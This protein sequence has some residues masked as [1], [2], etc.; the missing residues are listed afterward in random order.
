MLKNRILFTKGLAAAKYALR[1]VAVATA[2]LAISAPV[3][4]ACG[5]NSFTA[6]LQFTGTGPF[7]GGT[8]T[9]DGTVV[10]VPGD[11][12]CATD[13]VVRTNDVFVYRFNYK[14]PTGA[15]ENDITFTNTLPLGPGG[16]KIAVWDN[17]PPQCSGP[18]SSVSP[19]GLTLVCNIGSKDQSAPG[20]GDL[21]SS[22][23]AQV[24]STV[25]GANND[26]IQPGPATVTTS[27]PGTDPLNPV[28]CTAV[29][30]APQTPPPVTVSARPKVDFR[31][32][33]PYAGGQTPY[34]YNGVP[35]YLVSWYIYMDQAESSGTPSSKG[36]ESLNSPITLTDVPT[37]FPASAIWFDCGR[38]EG[39]QGTIACPATGT[40]VT[41]SQ[42]VTITAQPGEAGEFMIAGGKNTNIQLDPNTSNPARLATYYQRFWIPLSAVENTSINLRNDIPANLIAATSLSGAPV[43]DPLPGNNGLQITVIGTGPGSIAKFLTKEWG[44]SPWA[45]PT[46]GSAGASG[47]VQLQGT[48]NY[49]YSGT[50]V[51]FPGQTFYPMLRYYNGNAAAATNLTQ[52]ENFNANEVRLVEIPGSAGQAAAN[53]YQTPGTFGTANADFPGG[54]FVQ[55]GVST[56]GNP[57]GGGDL[58]EDSNATWYL[59]LTAATAAGN[60]ENLNKVRVFFP[61]V[62]SNVLTEF[63][64]AQQSRNNVNGT[65]IEDHMLNKGANTPGPDVGPWR[66]SFFDEN[67]NAG[68]GLGLKLTLTTAIARVQKNASLQP[69]GPSINQAVAGG[70]V[71]Y[72]LTPSLQSPVLGLPA[73][74]VTVVDRLPAPL[75]YVD[76]S[77]RFGNPPSPITPDS[78]V[79]DAGGTTITWTL[80]GVVPNTPIPD[81]TFRALVPF[82][83]PPNTSVNN[84]VVISSPQDTSEE[85]VRSANKALT[86]LNAPG[87][88]VSKSTS[89][90]AIDVAG[91]ATWKIQVS[92]FNIQ[93]TVADVI[94]VLP[95]TALSGGGSGDGRFPPSAFGGSKGILAPITAPNN[96][97]VPVIYYTSVASNLIVF[98]PLTAPVPAAPTWCTFAEVGSVAGCPANL[99]AA[100]GFRVTNLTILA[101]A[102]SDISYNMPTTGNTAGDVYTNR[103]YV[104]TGDPLLSTL[105]SNDVK[106]VVKIGSISGKVYRDDDGNATQGG[107]EP[108][109]QGVT[110][111]LCKINPA[112]TGGICPP[113]S[114]QGVGVTDAA[115]NY[116]IPGVPSSLFNGGPYYLVETQPAGYANGPNNAPGSLGGTAG[117]NTVSAITMPVGGNGTNYNFGERY[118]DLTTKVQLPAA[119]TG[120]APSSGT[121]TFANASGVASTATVV[122][123]TLSP[124]LS[125]VSVVAP[126][127]WVA[128]AYDPITGNIPL[129]RTGGVIAPNS[130]FDFVVNFNAPLNGEI[131][132]AST[133]TNSLADL[134]PIT[135]PLSTNPK[136]N[137][138]IV[139]VRVLGPQIDT[140][141]RAGVPQPLT[142]LTTPS[143]PAVGFLVPYSISVG[144]RSPATVTKMQAADSLL[145]TFPTT[146]AADIS[147][148]SIA[149]TSGVFGTQTVVPA[150]TPATAYDGKTQANFFSGT[151][152]LLPGQVCNIALQV[153]LQYANLAAIPGTAQQNNVWAS[154]GVFGAANPGPSFSPTGSPTFPGGTNTTDKSTDSPQ[155]PPSAAGT[156][157]PAPGIGTQPPGADIPDPTTVNLLGQAIDVR[158][159]S[160]YAVQTDVS[161]R[162]FR[163]AYTVNVS[164]LTTGAATNVQLSE[165][166]NFTFKA[167]ATFV[168]G[169]P[170]VVS[171]PAGCTN[172]LNTNF[173]GGAVNALVAKNYNLFRKAS[174]L[175]D[176]NSDLT[177][178]AGTSCVISFI[179]DVDYGPS[180]VPV[181]PL[182]AQNR[183]FGST[184]SG[185]N[186]GPPF[187]ADGTKNGDNPNVIDK[188]TSANVAPTVATYGTPPADP[189][190][191]SGPKADAGS[192]T[193]AIFKTLEVK[194]AVSGP[195]QTLAKGKYLV[196]YKVVVTAVGPALEVL[197]N[198]QVVDNLRPTYAT[199]APTLLVT[200][201][202]V[203]NAGG[204]SGCAPST[205]PAYTGQGTNIALLAGNSSLT[206]GQSCEITFNV[207]VDYG[208]NGTV[209]IAP[210]LNT[211][212]ASSVNGATNPGGTVS[213]TLP[214]TGTATGVWVPPTV[215]TLV[216]KDASTD[217]ITPPA[218]TSA[219]DTPVPTA[220]TF[221]PAAALQ[222]IK[223]VENV[224]APG[225]PPVAGSAIQW[226]IVYKNAGSTPATNVQVNDSLLPLGSQI[227]GVIASIAT[228]PS[229][230]TAQPN[231][232][233]NGISNTALLA[234]PITIPAGGVLTIKIK[235]SINNSPAFTGALVNQASLTSAETGG[236]SGTPLPTSAVNPGY[237]VC[238]SALACIPAGVT[239]PASALNSA[240]STVPGQTNTLAI[241][242]AGSITG[243]AWR[244]TQSNDIN[245]PGEVPVPGIRVAVYAIDPVTGARIVEVTNPNNR[246]VTNA[247]GDYT[248]NG[249]APSDP[250]VPGGPKYEIVFYNEAGTSILSGGTSQGSITAN[251]GVTTD[252]SKIKGVTVTPGGTTTGQN[253]PLDPSGVVYDSVTR[254]PVPGA[255]VAL[256][257]PPGFDPNIHL[258]GGAA[259]QSQS[260]GP[261]GFYQFILQP[262]AP[263][264]VYNLVVT[265]P[266]NYAQSTLIPPQPSA[267]PAQP[268]GPLPAFLVQAQPGA[269]TGAQPTPYY[270]SFNVGAG[271]RDIIHNHIPLDSGS[272]RKLALIKTVNKPVAEFGDVVMYNL[273]LRN[274]GNAAVNGAFINDFLPAG[275]RY[276]PGTA[277]ISNPAGVALVA[278]PDP[279]GSPGP[280]LRFNIAGNIL[281]NGEVSI[282]Y[283]VRLGVGSLQGDGINRA[284]GRAN[285]AVSNEA[286][287]VV[288][289]EPGVFTSEACL[290][291]KVFVDCNNNHIQDA[292]EVGVPNVRLYLNDGTNFIT[293]SEG[294]Y[295]YCGLQPKSHVITVDLLTMPRGSR[296][297]TTSNRNLGDANSLFLDIKN[298]ELVRADFAEG[299]CSNTV[300]EQV[301]ARRGKGEVRAPG[302]E[303]K[304]QPALKWEG[305]SP[306]FP[307]QGTNS[308][309]QILVAPRPPNG[310]LTSVPEQNKPVPQLPAA[311]SNTPGANLREAK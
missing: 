113:L 225:T 62:A 80:N 141:K 152:D 295:S 189:L 226:T 176:K 257:G 177:L 219:V 44:G 133:I 153:K 57:P 232:A 174:D 115:G 170:T 30:N 66:R 299:S 160:S 188:D 307:Q 102:T 17:L 122:S 95:Y 184:A 193:P 274:I 68:V 82:T 303:K 126:T 103:F 191:P 220:V 42:P 107:S 4:A 26:I 150:C 147:V 144:N 125:G 116:N 118:T 187:L 201:T 45:G 168:A 137:A 297:T 290:A 92:N 209:P 93:S 282:F 275:F 260:V 302:T 266:A 28:S 86:V 7:N 112:P 139:K 212:Y 51:V 217:G 23:V 47:D 194:K 186:D 108:P 292:E 151:F 179:A 252:R 265:P 284:Q 254:N 206:V 48:N 84:R 98:D 250:A 38:A 22:L 285:G 280:A 305:K 281:V 9:P 16:R 211:A 40:P 128:G 12:A 245:D 162:R 131:S 195:I 238:P 15:L 81:I 190:P 106:T 310:G 164:N 69:G 263:L 2:A 240:L 244:E 258:V 6:G 25:F 155:V 183:V 304:G 71:T 87:V 46:V 39:Q 159:S 248:I 309:N 200:S 41:G 276:I 204:A 272:Q 101:N 3:I 173:D 78:V 233:W 21:T 270:L 203:I 289:V 120:N 18:G 53:R 94:D 72:T 264:G 145:A 135:D 88:Y 214:G 256:T 149:Y 67:T 99:A 213:D 117:V 33:F 91:T 172:N 132:L 261:S 136:K 306:R 165:N 104:K 19:D 222:G 230:T 127:G 202:T 110:V 61:V 83:I 85:N 114:V 140:R 119:I 109:I 171:G 138:D 234:T 296:M 148:E 89:T 79:V 74:F 198:V 10:A 301:N 241:A 196:P 192:G 247:N 8:C 134:T 161:G 308:A 29:N 267:L 20:S 242:Q 124:G 32:D 156:V 294:K 14:I 253:L 11:D 96:G 157:P 185:P 13:S 235:S 279:V 298:G 60:R 54:Y 58:C 167:P 36:G 143:V 175:A 178:S 218:G 259:N 180:V 286:R 228:N 34:T 63:V 163:I 268:G 229:S 208:V 205:A 75:E 311:S 283:K 182:T 239:V 207:T 37:N 43:V 221:T 255:V 271:N 154:G 55:Y 35:G 24:R 52:C 65:I 262:G 227:A 199:G 246:P 251:N 100:T 1:K 293:D 130:G 237:P 169:T 121:V 291:G 249:L 210:Q 231:P 97:T 90:P 273:R 287:A 146:P 59:S 56:A 197:P 300:M 64:I 31:K 50:G 224:D 5:L 158:K 142:T 77:A 49:A 243:K 236:P 111:T 269:P 76:G 73:T 215:G 277:Q 27:G 181:A 123:I 288:K 166:L 223:Y 216:A 129:T 278:M 105:R 70:S